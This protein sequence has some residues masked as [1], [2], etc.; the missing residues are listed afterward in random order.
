MAPDIQTVKHIYT[1]LY[2][3]CSYFWIWF[4]FPFFQ[5]TIRAN[6]GNAKG[7]FP[8]WKVDDIHSGKIRLIWWLKMGGEHSFG[9]ISPRPFPIPRNFNVIKMCKTSLIKIKCGYFTVQFSGG[10]FVVL[11]GRKLGSTFLYVWR[12][13]YDWASNVWETKTFRKKWFFWDS[14]QTLFVVTVNW[15]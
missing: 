9:A 2:Y 5:A 15:R 10:Q 11:V 4:I 8:C 1:T 6:R 13:V 7:F 14:D 3:R 12:M